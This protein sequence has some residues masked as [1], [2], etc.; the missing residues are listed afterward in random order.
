[1]VRGLYTA[2]IGMTA[3]LN[4]FDVISNN[5]ANVNTTGYK[6]D[7]VITQSFSEELMK[8][9]DDP[10]L[11]QISHSVPIGQMR[12]GIFVDTI[13][14][15][16]TTG[17]ITETGNEFDVAIVGDG[18]FT[19]SST[20]E[21]GNVTERYSKDGSFTLMDGLLVSKDGKPVLGQSGQINIPD[22]DVEINAL[23]GIYVNGEYIDTLRMVSFEDAA[24]ENGNYTLR[25]YGENLYSM[26]NESQIAD[27]KGQL[28][29][30]AVEA[31]NVNPV[32]EM[33]E[34]ITIN[35]LYESNQRVITAIDQTLSRAVN[36]I[37]RR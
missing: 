34:M 26:T 10:A 8:R 25:K 27:F 3:S 30:G 6:K 28:Q 11:N 36:D 15:D 17:S 18:F 20:D 7:S 9:L 24:G 1:V 23:G 21:N 16:F 37:A 4:R 13:T 33:V 2:G 31:S 29:Q 19:V 5:I 32:R 22:G 14:T 12:L 35:R